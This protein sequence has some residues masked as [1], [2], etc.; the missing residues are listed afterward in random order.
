MDKVYIVFNN[1]AVG[2]DDYGSVVSSAVVAGVFANKT[3]AEN[4]ANN[5]SGWGNCYIEEYNIL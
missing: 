4:A 3:D 5:F 2:Y 1:V